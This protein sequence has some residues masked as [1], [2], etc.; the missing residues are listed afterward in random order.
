M[1]DP[2]TKELRYIGYSSE[3]ERR[4]K[5][6]HRPIYLK[7][8]THKNNWI[9]SLL[10]QGQRA[11]FI[12]IEEYE[13]ADELPQAEIEMVEYFRYLGV[14]LTNGTRGGDG[15]RK[16]DKLSEETKKKLSEAFSG[17]KHPM[18]GKT[19]SEEVRKKN[20]RSC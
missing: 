2:L 20:I 4:I 13:S 3:I 16:G 10:S 1:I 14:N 18:Y 9:K 5:D 6:H 15:H 11:E 12:I 8:K 19:H 7:V 17:E